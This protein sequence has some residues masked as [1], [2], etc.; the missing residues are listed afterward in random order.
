MSPQFA[1]AGKSEMVEFEFAQTRPSP[2]L[3]SNTSVY[4]RVCDWSNEYRMDFS[5][6]SIGR[7]RS[8]SDCLISTRSSTS[9]LVKC[10]FNNK[11]IMPKGS[12]QRHII[13]CMTNYPHFVTCPHNA[14]HRFPDK[15]A[16]AKHVAICDSQSKSFLF[17]EIEGSITTDVHIENIEEFN[18]EFENWDK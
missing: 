10:P 11:H 2:H 8:Q 5:R 18:L 6:H 15:E 9:T 4:K 3:L 12:L 14:L 7:I 1:G 16:L 17:H 13:K